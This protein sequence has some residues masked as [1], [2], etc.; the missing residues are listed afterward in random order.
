[1]LTPD[2]GPKVIEYNARFGD[3]EAMNV[4]P[5][6]QGDFVEICT[7]VTEGRL[8]EVD[9]SFANRA[10]VCKYLVPSSYPMEVVD[11]GRI[12]LPEG[13]FDESTHWYWAACEQQENHVALT[14]SRSGAAVG[15][16]ETLKQA[17]Q[18]A[19]RAASQVAGDVRH[20]SDIGK[21][22]IVQRR[23]D[24]MVSLRPDAQRAEAHAA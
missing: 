19:E 4:L 3:P 20:R 17:E 9:A 1:M 13:V 24:H 7:A 23:I 10:T 8:G 18:L 12:A 2:G 11:P 15:I 14:G 6:L 21:P 16:G 5:L 22:E